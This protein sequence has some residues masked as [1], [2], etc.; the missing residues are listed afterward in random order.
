MLDAKVFLKLLQ[1]D[2]QAN[3]PGAPVT[4]VWLSATP[5]EPRRAQDGLFLPAAPQAE[6]LE[7]TL[8]KIKRVVG[9]TASKSMVES[10][11]SGQSSAAGQEKQR[12]ASGTQEV[13]EELVGS[14]ELLDTHRPDGFTMKKFMSANAA[15][16]SIDYRPS[17]P[18]TALRLFR[19][20]PAAA[21]AL[22]DGRPARLTCPERPA[23]AGA[24]TWCAGPW[25]SSGEWWSEQAWWREEW[26]VAVGEALYR[27]YRDT[28]GWFVE[29]SYD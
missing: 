1:L 11:A 15:P 10:M 9:A 28:T 29:G 3:P 6:R 16:S 22:R 19:P 24:V 25:R 20:P 12:A 17:T 27:I 26:D 7:V 14:P 21:V 5:A 2:L 23:L 8:A 13:V 18:I 4:K